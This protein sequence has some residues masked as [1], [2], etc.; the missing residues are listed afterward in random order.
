MSLQGI[1][2]EGVVWHVRLLNIYL[3]HGVDDVLHIL[4]VF[5]LTDCDSG[6]DYCLLEEVISV[7]FRLAADQLLFVHDGVKLAREAA[8]T[9]RGSSCARRSARHDGKLFSI[10]NMLKLE[11]T[12][13]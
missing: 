11:Y 3:F 5:G 1:H 12:L 8:L 10:F 7:G 2:Q 13:I 6:V 4:R 9:G